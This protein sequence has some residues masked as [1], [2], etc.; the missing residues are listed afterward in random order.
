MAP[1]RTRDTRHRGNTS[2]NQ[3]SRPLTNGGTHGLTNGSS[4]NDPR[5]PAN[6]PSGGAPDNSSPG[7]RI[8]D[9]DDEIVDGYVIPGRFNNSNFGDYHAWIRFIP[10]SANPG[11]PL[12]DDLHLA[13]DD[14]LDAHATLGRAWSDNLPVAVQFRGERIIRVTRR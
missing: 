14:A 6:T 5:A 12:R 2:S 3:Q 4:S 1:H 11:E 10:N 13:G 9:A 8:Q 7:S